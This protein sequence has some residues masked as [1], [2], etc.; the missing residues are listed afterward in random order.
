MNGNVKN[1][2]LTTSKSSSEYFT[3][4]VGESA[5]GAGEGQPIVRNATANR[6]IANTMRK[7]STKLNALKKCLSEDSGLA[8]LTH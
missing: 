5:P 1:P 6:M 4:F 2:V 3:K 8:T 7:P